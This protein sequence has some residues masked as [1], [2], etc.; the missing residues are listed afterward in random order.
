[1][2][3][4]NEQT[5]SYTLQPQDNNKLV[6]FNAST[7]I[8]ATLPKPGT[9]PWMGISFTCW[10]ANI[11]A[12][13]LTISPTSALIDGGG[14]LVLTTNQGV[15]LFNDGTNFFT[16]RGT[17]TGG[18]GT[19]LALETN[20]TPNGSQTLLNLAAGTNVTIT[21]GGTG[22]VTISSSGS[23]SGNA[24]DIQSVP[25]SSTAPTTGQ[26]LEYNG[27][28]WAPAISSGAPPAI[29]LGPDW[30]PASPTT[31]DDEFTEGSLDPKWTVAA[32]SGSGSPVVSGTFLSIG[33]TPTG[34]DHFT[35]VLQ[36][37][38]ATPYAI[39][40]KC[41][42]QG[43]NINFYYGGLCLGDSTGKVITLYPQ[44]GPEVGFNN[45][46]SNTSYNSS[47]GSASVVMGAY[48][49]LRF[50]DDGTNITASYSNDGVNFVILAVVSRT[51]FL[52]AGPTLMGLMGGNN[53]STSNPETW[54]SCD[55]FRRTA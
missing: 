35:T 14:S 43:P 55:W 5:A 2:S 53:L 36:S 44:N 22:T 15:M 11:G 4:V 30:P 32:P 24:T 17:G 49:Y 19:S 29:S 54:F 42:M 33:T 1:M 8:T 45:W 18:G 31:Y 52:T 25:V 7:A 34:S 47:N 6:L 39:T 3:W 10:L 51:A 12:G 13:N 9:P 41:F 16:V 20:G 27:T 21:D 40:A 50:A 46:N 23:G 28:Q 48:L 38:P 26:V 37:V